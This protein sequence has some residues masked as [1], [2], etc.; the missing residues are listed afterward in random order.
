M[1]PQPAARQ[2]CRD[3][4]HHVLRLLPTVAMNYRIICILGE[5]TVRAGA[6]HPRVEGVVHEQIHQD[7]LVH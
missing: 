2:P 7:G 1:H 3:R 6:L 5:R 4:S